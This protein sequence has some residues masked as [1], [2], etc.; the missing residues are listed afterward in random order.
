MLEKNKTLTDKEAIR[1]FN[2][3]KHSVKLANIATG[4]LENGYGVAY[5]TRIDLFNAIH[6]VRSH[7]DTLEEFNDIIKKR[8]K[9]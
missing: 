7:L 6:L 8:A 5:P 3:L 4:I 2:V 1:L 9:K